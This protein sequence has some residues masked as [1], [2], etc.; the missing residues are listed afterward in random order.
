[1]K[2][3]L[4]QKFE[5]ILLIL[6]YLRKIW[7]C[8]TKKSTCR[9]RDACR[10]AESLSQ[11]LYTLVNAAPA[12]LRYWSVIPFQ[13]TRIVQSGSHRDILYF[14]AQLIRQ[15]IG[16]VYL[17]YCSILRL[18]NWLSGKQSRKIHN[19]ITWAISGHFIASS[20]CVTRQNI[21]SQC[22]FIELVSQEILTSPFSRRL[23]GAEDRDD[24]WTW[25]N[26]QSQ[27]WIAL[28]AEFE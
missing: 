10:G 27:T 28:V 16:L 19:D 25:I 20:A 17:F 18:V 21:W 23:V 5:S 9:V 14:V 26:F 3:K 8:K 13:V 22:F 2:S 24:G 7:C 6:N 15:G 12:R 1:M 4:T 11:V